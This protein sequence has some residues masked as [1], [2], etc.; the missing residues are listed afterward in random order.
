MTFSRFPSFT[1]GSWLCLAANLQGCGS[2]TPELSTDMPTPD[3]A[4]FVSEVYPVLLRDCAFSSCHGAPERFLQVYGPRRERL[5]PDTEIS[6]PLS[7]DEV[8][9]TYDRARSMLASTA[10]PT[11]SLLLRKPLEISAGG[12]AHRGADAFGRNVFQSREDNSY[13]ILL[14]WAGSSG[15]PPSEDDVKAA[16]EAADRAIINWAGAGL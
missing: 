4:Q 10:D 15:K 16:G 7:L 8:R 5:D 14:S 13:Q 11:L 3:G 12:Q 2:Q 9:Y 1:L 6:G